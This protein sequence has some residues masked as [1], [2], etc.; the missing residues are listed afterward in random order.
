MKTTAI[1][2]LVESF[3]E[4]SLLRA[5]ADLLEGKHPS[6]PVPGDDEGEQLTHVIGA[7]WVTNYISNTGMGFQDA[8]IEYARK[9]RSS[10]S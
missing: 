10:I 3:E 2:Q 8:L 5:E 1:R 7:L 4:S 6:I 9:V